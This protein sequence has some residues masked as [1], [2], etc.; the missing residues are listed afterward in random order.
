MTGVLSL[1]VGFVLG[2]F[3]A[4]TVRFWHGRLDEHFQRYDELRDVLLHAADISADYWL[5]VRDL[6]DRQAEARLTG[7][8]RRLNGLAAGLAL[9]T[10]DNPLAHSERLADFN[11]LI[12]G[13]PDYENDQREIDVARAMAVQQKTADLVL[14]FQKYRRSRLTLLRSLRMALLGSTL[15]GKN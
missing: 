13:G 9:A 11:D 10:K 5:K 15:V 6:N 7:L 1:L 8:F 4:F 2:M 12:T 3:A 14:Y